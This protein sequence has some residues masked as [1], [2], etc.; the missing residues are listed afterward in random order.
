MRILDESQALQDVWTNRSGLGGYGQGTQ[1]DVGMTTRVFRQGRQDNVAKSWGLLS[2]SHK[3]GKEERRE[4]SRVNNDE[5]SSL[6][7][8][9]VD[10]P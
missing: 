9:G 2:L 3:R 8:Q 7:W 10:N 4:E 1:Y 5:R 6:G